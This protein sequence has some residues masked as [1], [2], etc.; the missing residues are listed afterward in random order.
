MNNIKKEL[1]R[2]LVAGFLVVAIDATVY[3]FLLFLLPPSLSKSIAFVVGAI[4]AYLI[5][6]FWTFKKS[7]FSHGEII[8]FVFLYILAMA[9]NVGINSLAIFLFNSLIF[10][11]LLATGTSASFNFIGQKFFVF[12]EMFKKTYK[13]QHNQNR[14]NDEGDVRKARANFLKNPSNNL[15]FLLENRYKWMNEYIKEDSKGV[16]V[17]CG[18]GIGKFY[19]KSENFILTDYSDGDWLDVKNVDALNMPFESESFDFVVS[20]NMIHHVPYPL[21]FFEEMFRILKPGG[22]LLIQEVNASFFMRLILRLMRHEGYSFEVDVF[23]KEVIC[24]DKDDLWS[25]N[26]A[27]SNIIFDDKNKFERNIPY[28][29]IIKEAY[30]EFFILLNSGGVIAKTFYIPLPI[31][32]LKIIK[33][34]DDILTKNFPGIFALQRKIV[35]KK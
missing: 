7:G 24:T 31:F 2:F 21:K 6:K 3:Y 5:N 27:I 12:K 10:A 22:V 26:C 15:K 19:I 18:A 4:A 28:F 33:I 16:E 9:I 35:F 23:N 34:I 32:A 25:A 1:P 30:G 13:P 14:M 17:G 11:Y 20:S 8:K 29:K